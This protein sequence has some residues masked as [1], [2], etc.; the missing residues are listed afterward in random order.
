MTTRQSSELS[1]VDAVETLSSIADMD[2]D[3]EIGV[4]QSHELDVQNKK[5]S[6]RTV[7]WLRDRD[8]K[9]SL[10]VIKETFRVILNYLRNFYRDEYRSLKDMQTIE[11]V[12]T[13]MVL[14]GEAAK[15]LDR[16]NKEFLQKKNFSVTKLKEYK[17]LQQF[18]ESRI[19]KRVDDGKLSKWIL[20]LT[21]MAESMP[22]K[23]IEAKEKKAW[24]TK[25]IFV[26]LESVKKDT[27]YELFLLRKED[28]TRF[29]SPRL[30]RNM[31]LVSDFG[32]YFGHSEL[33][34]PLSSLQQWEDRCFHA[35]AQSIIRSVGTRADRFFHEAGRYKG[36][37]LPALLIQTLMALMLA[38][39]PNNLM[40]NNPPKNCL[41]YFKDFQL[42]LREAM[43]SR[44]YQRL[45]AYPP[46]EQDRLGCSIVET[47][48]ALCRALYVHMRGYQ[49]MVPIIQELITESLNEDGNQFVDGELWEKIQN[50]YDALQKV[51]KRHPNG[52]LV[53]VLDLLEAGTVRQF[54]PLH[55]ENVPT[56]LFHLYMNDSRMTCM[57]MASPTYQE[58]IHRVHIVEEFLGFLRACSSDHIIRKHLIFNLQDRTS[59]REVARCKAIEG[60]QNVKQFHDHLVVVTLPI[61]TE[62]YHQMAPYHDENK[63]KVFM[64]HFKEH[65]GD[66]NAGFYFPDRLKG[67]LFPEFSNAVMDAIHR[68]FFSGKNILTHSERL[69]FIEIFYFFLQL[70]IME[71]VR[72]DS[73]SMTCKDAIDI[74]MAESM[75]L[76]AF[77]KL[78]NQVELS[79]SDYDCLHFMLF[80]PSLLIRERLLLPERFSRMI[81]AMRTVEEARHE[82]GPETF[83]L[84]VNEVF[85]PHYKSTI[86]HAQIV[87]PHE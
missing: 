6:Y 22:Q 8:A 45:V 51:L 67:E 41:E 48:H 71:L 68:I 25:Y 76:F 13:I 19:S 63:A 46:N 57:R 64:E 15:K 29:F 38:G 83:P 70:K 55:Q 33:D 27:E 60:L 82:F 74:G 69:D 28:G 61:D 4:T 14:V 1:L 53:K 16:Y 35:S 26:D 85:G 75:Q 5:V 34:D 39:N 24:E 66:E 56:P 84:V 18:Y 78:F 65:L 17:E 72:P 30:I 40:R 73:L 3:K 36:R 77:L 20:G 37:E 59:W 43:H 42:F 54:D 31:K 86:L 49:E 32:S 50:E 12:K 52:G 44:H 23:Q 79:K 47:I 2:F 11:G 87:V 81:S 58:F 9:E 21:Q 62:F 10:E 7:H 80:A